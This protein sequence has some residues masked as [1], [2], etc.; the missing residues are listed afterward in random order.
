MSALRII[1]ETIYEYTEP[2]RF[3]THRLVLRPRESHD[4]QVERMSLAIEPAHSLEWSRDVFGNSVAL[5]E[6]L[7]HSPQLPIVNQLDIRR[8]DL[9][10]LADRGSVPIPYPL[11]YDEMEA[12]IASAYRVSGSSYGRSAPMSE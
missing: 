11:V 5:V 7:A 9:A 1:H 2:V 3:G 10:R 4:L 6:F 8:F 12:V